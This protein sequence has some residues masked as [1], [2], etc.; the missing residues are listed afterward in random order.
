MDFPK[1]DFGDEEACFK[2]LVQWHHSVWP[3]CPDCYERD[4][5]QVHQNHRLHWRVCYHCSRCRRFFNAW[6][7][8]RLQGTQ[9][10]P[11]E[12]LQVVK[13]MVEGKSTRIIAKEI[14]RDRDSVARLRHR[15]QELVLAKFGPPPEKSIACGEG[16]AIFMS[17]TMR[18]WEC[19][20]GLQRFPGNL[21][22][23]NECAL[24]SEIKVR[25]LGLS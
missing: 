14:G 18:L 24:T 12:I 10:T 9:F 19:R 25:Q 8:T 23:S 11:L 2:L 6:S 1:V 17:V 3:R 5:I 20:K 13:G 21:N 4:E 16:H 22:E 7:K 15:V